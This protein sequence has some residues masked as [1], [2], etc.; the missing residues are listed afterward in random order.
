MLT[1][2]VLLKVSSVPSI[3]AIDFPSLHSLKVI[4][5]YGTNILGGCEKTDTILMPMCSPIFQAGIKSRVASPVFIF[6]GMLNFSGA[7]IFEPNA[8]LRASINIPY[9][10]DE[11]TLFLSYSFKNQSLK[12]TNCKGIS[13]LP[14]LIIFIT[15]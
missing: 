9:C 15:A 6:N 7:F 10:K 2:V 12:F 5:M 11:A 8:F 13:N 3:T 14:S 1:H 4:S